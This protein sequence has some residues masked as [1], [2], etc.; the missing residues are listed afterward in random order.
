MRGYLHFLLLLCPV[1][2][3]A[4]SGGDVGGGSKSIYHPDVGPF[5][6]NGDYV[7]ALADAPVR[8]N[9]FAR[10]GSSNSQLQRKPSRTVRPVPEPP[11]LLAQNQAREGRRIDRPSFAPNPASSPV[12]ARQNVSSSPVP[13]DAPVPVVESRPSLPNTVVISSTPRRDTPPPPRTVAQAAPSKAAP[14]KPRAVVMTPKKAPPVRHV[15]KSSDTLFGLSKKYRVSVASI[16]RAN[17]LRGNTI[18]TGKS[19][20]IPR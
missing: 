20:L 4:C 14:P 18:V 10:N 2:L 5:D 12:P 1:V 13:Q 17:G 15:V 19:L 3:V 8:K 9:H 11:R 6:E 16:Q 7:I